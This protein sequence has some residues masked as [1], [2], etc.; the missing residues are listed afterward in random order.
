LPKSNLRFA[1]HKH[2][3]SY[4]MCD[5]RHNSRS[6]SWTVLCELPPAKRKPQRGQSNRA[7]PASVQRKVCV[8]A[9]SCYRP[10]PQA[11]IKGDTKAT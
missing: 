1:S 2:R 5:R 10:A 4:K 9:G 3:I 6:A 7:N 8:R 11:Q